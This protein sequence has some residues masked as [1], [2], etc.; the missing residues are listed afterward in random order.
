[1]Q[2]VQKAQKAS[3]RRDFLRFL[4]FV[5]SKNGL[6]GGS[7]TKAAGRA[8]DP[9]EGGNAPVSGALSSSD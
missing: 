9:P 3:E 2:K 8:D 1:M 5:H 6:G 4:Q 7:P